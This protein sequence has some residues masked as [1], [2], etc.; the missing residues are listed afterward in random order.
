[1]KRLSTLVFLIA[2]CLCA[3]GQCPPD[4][5][6]IPTVGDHSVTNLSATEQ[7]RRLIIFAPAKE[8]FWL[9]VNDQPQTPTPTNIAFADLKVN[10]IYN[11]LIVVNDRYRSTIREKICIGG[12]NETLVLTMERDNKL[13]RNVYNLWWKNSRIRTNPD[14]YTYIWEDLTPQHGRIYHSGIEVRPIAQTNPSI[15]QHNYTEDTFVE[16]LKLFQEENFDK[17]RLSLAKEIFRDRYMSSK[18]IKE[19]AQ[20]FTFDDSRLEFLKMAYLKCLDRENFYIVYS[21][22]T[23][24][25]SK[26]EL[27]KYLDSIH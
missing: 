26:E 3:Q 6:N 13:S 14:H 20:I 10:H 8:Q 1:M 24:S 15:P 5:H 2:C 19:I 21:T 7:T 12:N 11:I 17:N 25:S 22:F 23:F 18:E 9:Y 16:I 4:P 27:S